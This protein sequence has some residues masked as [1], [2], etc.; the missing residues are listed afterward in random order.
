MR[1]ISFVAA[2]RPQ[3]QEAFLARAR[4]IIDQEPSLAG[5][6][7]VTFPYNTHMFCAQRL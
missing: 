7:S 6:T 1:S 3:E 2:M 5:A 4:E